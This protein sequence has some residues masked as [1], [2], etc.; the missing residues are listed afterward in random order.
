MFGAK[1]EFSIGRLGSG[2]LI[3]NYRCTSRCGHCLYR[4]SPRRTQEYIDDETT[5]LNLEK[6]RSLGCRS[7]HIGGGEP[8]LDAGRLER[9]L[10]IAGE[11]GVHVEYVETNSSWY[12]GRDA[13][14]EILERLRG[15]GLSTLLVSI[16]PFHNEFI[17]FS[18]VKGVIEA[19]RI[20]GVSVFPWIREFHGEVD[21]FDDKSPHR[22]SEY[23]DKFG[24]NYLAR[25][26]SRYWVHF[27]GRALSTFENVF[28]SRDCRGTISSSSLTCP[29][30][31]DVSHFHFDLYGNY[32][33][34]LC[35][36]LSIRR[37]DLGKPLAPEEYPILTTLLRSGIHGLFKTAS[38]EHGFKPSDRYLSKC[39]LCNDIRR[40]LVREVKMESKELQP[41]GYYEDW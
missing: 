38:E 14:C 26:P 8:F 10:E 39:H 16:S 11:T 33:P 35:S 17:P 36:G 9:V 41:V 1:K 31:L 29:E 3:T 15:R 20:A 25:I 28:E 18:R 6:I 22:L 5:R 2:G 24:R 12:T 32:I 13:A 19:C 40:H 30:L 23:T 34:G 37:D 7:V 21:S 27:G 4:C